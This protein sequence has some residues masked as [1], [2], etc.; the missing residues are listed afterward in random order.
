MSADINEV[1]CA[2]PGRR[3]IVMIGHA[4]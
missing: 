4:E 2:L 3:R 1:R